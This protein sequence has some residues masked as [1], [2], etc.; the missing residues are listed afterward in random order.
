MSVKQSSGILAIW[1]DM[2]SE[3][4]QVLNDWYNQEHHAERIA[5]EGFSAPAA[6]SLLKPRRSFCFLRNRRPLGAGDA[7]LSRLRQ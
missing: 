3:Q 2:V 1:H 7:G 5:L 4:E 6:I